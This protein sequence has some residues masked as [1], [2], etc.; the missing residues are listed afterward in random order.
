MLWDTSIQTA[1]SPTTFKA[2]L[3]ALNAKYTSEIELI[4]EIFARDPATA[5][6]IK[7]MKE[8]PDRAE[9]PLQWAIWKFFEIRRENTDP[10]TGKVDNRAFDKAWE[11]ETSGWDDEEM[12]ESGGLADR[13]DAWL[14]TGDHHPFVQE[15]YDT[16]SALDKAGYWED[17]FPEQNKQINQMYAK[18]LA[19]GNTTVEEIWSDYLASSVE[20]R[21]RL[22]ASPNY[23]INNIIKSLEFARKVNRYNV[24][25][26]NPHLDRGLIKWFGNTP[27]IYGNREYYNQLYG[28]LPSTVRQSPYRLGGN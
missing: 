9:A 18:Q 5:E 10:V 4:E 12:Q 16:L 28:K 26:K 8:A 17:T 3:K 23:V 13:F 6:K 27:S 11:I 1:W 2:E 7:E 22:R 19:E 15:Y 14:N 25:I 20:E 21:R 24:V